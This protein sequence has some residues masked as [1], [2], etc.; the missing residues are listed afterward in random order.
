MAVLS[1][2]DLIKR[3]S[4]KTGA[5]QKES[6]VYLSAFL[7]SIR[8]SLQSGDE[9]RLIGFG[10][11]SVQQAAARTTI[12]PRTGERM[13]VPEKMRVKFSA[14][15]DLNEAVANVTLSK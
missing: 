7:E 4:E 2:Q 14:G 5:S 1:K 9:I 10:S 12:N 11:F 6:G 8:E 13:Q 3:I 15:K